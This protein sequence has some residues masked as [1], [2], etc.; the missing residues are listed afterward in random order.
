MGVCAKLVH[1]D[2]MTDIGEVVVLVPD[3]RE[4]VNKGWVL[5][6]FFCQCKLLLEFAEGGCLIFDVPQDSLEA[7]ESLPDD[8]LFSFLDIL[9]GSTNSF[10][11][12]LAIDFKFVIEQCIFLSLPFLY[13]VTAL[14]K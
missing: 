2:G 6:L 12:F 8:G 14:I 13:F 4:V 1:W 3:C 5:M 7:F 9:G 11:H 10:W